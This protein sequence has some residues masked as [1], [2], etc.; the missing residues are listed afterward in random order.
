MF[1]FICNSW[2]LFLNDCSVAPLAD[3]SRT[4]VWM[5]HLWWR[6][7]Q[8][9]HSSRKKKEW[10]RMKERKCEWHRNKRL[11]GGE[12]G[13]GLEWFNSRLNAVESINS[14]CLPILL[15]ERWQLKIR[16][17]DPGVSNR[18][19]AIRNVKFRSEFPSRSGVN[20]IAGAQNG[21]AATASNRQNV[22]A[23]LIGR[24]D[25]GSEPMELPRERLPTKSAGLKT[26]T[27][28]E[29]LSN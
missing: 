19:W 16:H 15:D 22:A 1:L 9:F 12:G 7:C 25:S 27:A 10:E 21:A 2:W 18:R 8:W 26:A 11:E 4:R 17:W 5:N 29:S 24:T 6:R 14:S 20:P 3:S 13:G 23:F 28:P